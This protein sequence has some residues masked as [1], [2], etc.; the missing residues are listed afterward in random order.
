MFA[1]RI[2]PPAKC[3]LLIDPDTKE[4]KT[5]SFFALWRELMCPDPQWGADDDGQRAFDELDEKMVDAEASGA[6]YLHLSDDTHAKF[7][8]CSRFQNGQGQKNTSRRELHGVKRD[9]P[10]TPPRP[11]H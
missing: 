8:A 7:L 2:P 9:Y 5:F 3:A 6:D 1:I 11:K 10:N 4:K